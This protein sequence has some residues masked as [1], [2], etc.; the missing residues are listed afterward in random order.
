MTAAL[1]QLVKDA[2]P[3]GISPDVLMR[4]IVP[5]VSR[6]TLNRQ[7]AALCDA[8]VIKPLGAGRATRYQTTT[9]FTRQE[10]DLYF[11]TPWT[12][13]P[14]A[15]FREDLLKP[16]PN[17]DPERAARCGQIQALANPMDGRYL[18][19]FLETF[20]WASG[21]LEGSSYTELDTAALLTYGE[22]NVDKPREDAV[23]ALNHARAAERLWTHREISL[24][25]LCAMHALLTDNHGVIAADESDHFLAPDQRGKP[26]DFEDVTL[27]DSA[28]TPPFRPGT[29][30]ARQVLEQI[31]ATALQLPAFEAAVYLLT[32][33]AYV[34]SFAN[35]NKRVSRV[36]A[37]LPLLAAGQIPFSFADVN[38]RDYIRGMAAFYELGAIHVIEQTFLDGYARSVVRSSRLPDALRVGG[39][40]PGEVAAHLVDYVNT[41]RRPKDR[42]ALAFLGPNP[43]AVPVSGP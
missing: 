12:A 13:R 40:D 4:R 19:T 15:P 28:Y 34:Q 3:A 30:H 17:I 9:P 31:V 8:G 23:L 1:A 10:I 36:A 7:L 42:R 26:R 20:S 32:R 22:R 24:E 18:K 35:G 14:L 11:E 2:G 41:G 16:T 6:S 27:H 29:G 25:N 33:V 39:F 38:K 5:A 37:N 21:V 43:S